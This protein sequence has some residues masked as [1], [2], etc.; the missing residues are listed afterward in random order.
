MLAKEIYECRPSDK[1]RYAATDQT[2]KEDYARQASIIQP[3]S[4]LEVFQKADRESIQA[5]SV[6]RPGRSLSGPLS[7]SSP[8]GSEG[9]G[10]RLTAPS[11]AVTYTVWY[12]VRVPR[13]LRLDDNARL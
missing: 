3:G 10:A 9:P 13:M 12:S 11:G 4:I 6:R 5:C 2:G 1:S 7:K 8:N